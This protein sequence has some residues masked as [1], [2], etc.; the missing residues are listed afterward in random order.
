MQYIYKVKA[1]CEFCASVMLGDISVE[2]A[3][4]HGYTYL[5]DASVSYSNITS[6][7]SLDYNLLGSKLKDICQ[8][9]DYCHLNDNVLLI[10]IEPSCENVAKIILEYLVDEL[11]LESGLEICIELS[12]RKDRGVSV[13]CI[14]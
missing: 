10:G 2:C 12:T 11:S 8:Q 6:S 1:S 13:S 3:Q 5:V 4:P 14:L 7:V 9:L